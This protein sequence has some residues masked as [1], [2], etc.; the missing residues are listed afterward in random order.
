MSTNA[1]KPEEHAKKEA[2]KRPSRDDLHEQR[3]A[4]QPREGVVRE[5]RPPAQSEIDRDRAEW[6]GMGQAQ[7]PEEAERPTRP[8]P[9]QPS[10][11]QPRR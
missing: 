4:A 3:D 1:N 6:E 5:G 11:T 10:V 7:A 8:S 9:G 2:A